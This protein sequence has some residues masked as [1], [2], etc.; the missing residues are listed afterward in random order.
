MINGTVDTNTDDDIDFNKKIDF[1]SND[2]NSWI[3][4]FYKRANASVIFREIQHHPAYST[5]ASAEVVG[6]KWLG[7]SEFMPWFLCQA[8]ANVSSNI[9]RT[10]ICRPAYEELGMGI[11]EEIHAELFRKC[12]QIVGVNSDS[13]H[14]PPIGMLRDYLNET[15]IGD[16]YIFGLCAG[17]EIIANDNI[18]NLF[19]N[20][21][22]TQEF[23]EILEGTEF[24]KLHRANEQGHIELTIGNFLRFSPLPADRRKFVEGFDR[25][26]EFWAQFWNGAALEMNPMNWIRN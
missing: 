14:V 11:P 10:Y 20:I 22:Y 12:L 8:A 19:R 2:L 18:E 7:F 23:K 15:G 24:F 4:I 21:A 3:V 9:K 13:N 1:L 16:D 25:A 26:I 5:R 17:L 6:A